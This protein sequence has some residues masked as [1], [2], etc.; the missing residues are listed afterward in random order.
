[1][2]ED[3]QFTFKEK[4]L[5]YTKKHKKKALPHS[6]IGVLLTFVI[7]MAAN[8]WPL[9]EQESLAESTN[10][11]EPRLT[12]SFVGDIMMGRYV[13]DVI[14]YRGSDFL[15][16]YAMPY[17]DE[18]DYVTGNF[19]HPV[20]IDGEEYE[21]ADKEIPLHAPESSINIMENAGF[22]V[23]NL[24]NNHILDYGQKGLQDTIDQ[25]A[26]SN[27][28]TVGHVQQPFIDYNQIDEQLTIATVGFNDV[29]ASADRSGVLES[30]P[31]ESLEYIKAADGEA[32]LVI[33]HVHIGVEYTSTPTQRQEDLMKAYVDAGA[34]IVIGHHPHVLQSVEHYNDGIIFYSLGNFIFDQGWTRTRD[35][36]LAQ[37]HLY[38]DGRA[39]IELVPFRIHE[40]QPRPLNGAGE[41]YFRQRIFQQLTKDTTDDSVYEIKDGRLIFEVDH[42]HVVD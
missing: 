37:Y 29:W 32:D 17:F 15:F 14:D 38:E 35:T 23:V 33:V 12:A 9:P 21:Q 24:A 5:A 13:E 11:E 22:S 7:L 30:D 8:W 1:M 36:A 10:E 34:D 27:V 18:A 42:S 16:H 26:Q 20:L 28:D 25:F 3:K 19:E 40:S 6:I 2:M 31:S 4:M 39:E 41:S